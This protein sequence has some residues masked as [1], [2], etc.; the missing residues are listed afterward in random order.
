MQITPGISA[1]DIL[2]AILAVFAIGV[3]VWA[4]SKANS[5]N[6][7]IVHIEEG[8]ERDR[9]RESRQA[10]LVASIEGARSP[11]LVIRNH[12]AAPARDIEVL[13][14]DEPIAKH[15]LIRDAGREIGT[16]GPGAE[17]HYSFITFDGMPTVYDIALRWSD[18]TGETREWDSR[19]T[20]Q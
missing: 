8:R 16:L 9:Q 18:G 5:A 2:T 6:A 19:L 20:M 14:D 17:T 4:A 12:G 11:L 1:A 15:Q 3:S 7:K 13:V 10:V